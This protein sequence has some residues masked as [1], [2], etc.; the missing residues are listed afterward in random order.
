ME[1]QP[2]VRSRCV[3]SVGAS[4]RF[5]HRTVFQPGQFGNEVDSLRA[6]RLSR[7]APMCRGSPSRSVVPGVGGLPVGP[8]STASHAFTS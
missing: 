7:C 5:L 8:V 6:A 4:G 3:W 1:R 2:V